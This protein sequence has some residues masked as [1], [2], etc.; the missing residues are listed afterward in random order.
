MSLDLSPENMRWAVQAMGVL[1]LSIC[2]H[3]YGHALL[4]DKLGDDLPRKQGRLTLNPLAHADPIGTLL[5]PLIG[6]LY[7][8]A[9]G[10]G[11]GKPVQTLPGRYTRRFDMRTG[12]M[13]VA[14]AGPCMNLIFGSMIAILH[15]VLLAT[16]VLPP[17]SAGA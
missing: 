14:L 13:F 16:D 11:W 15:A 2:V 1:L 4:A 3:E 12:H 8:G 7:A 6:I 10:F 9:P 17:E 5:F